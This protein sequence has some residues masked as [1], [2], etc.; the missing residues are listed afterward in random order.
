MKKNPWTTC[1]QT[2]PAMNEVLYQL[3]KRPH[4]L[5]AS[6]GFRFT[7]SAATK[8]CY[9]KNPWPLDA[10][11]SA[12]S[13]ASVHTD[14][15]FLHLLTSSYS[16]RMDSNFGAELKS[17]TWNPVS[18]TQTHLG[19]LG[20]PVATKCCWKKTSIILFFAN[21]YLKIIRPCPSMSHN[22][23]AKTKSVPS[24]HSC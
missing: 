12:V 6:G 11:A 13:L 9:R 3:Y 20:I 22:S 18:C 14:T 21:E 23:P 10:A 17:S 5:G 8:R 4:G 16:D 2:E 19:G 24:P 1:D 7:R 15:H